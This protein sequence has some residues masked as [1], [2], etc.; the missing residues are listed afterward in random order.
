MSFFNVWPKSDN[1]SHELVSEYKD[2]VHY[3]RNLPEGTEEIQTVDDKLRILEKQI[4]QKFGR[5]V[6]KDVWMSIE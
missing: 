6:V 3:M 5:Q 4:I 2:L 1:F